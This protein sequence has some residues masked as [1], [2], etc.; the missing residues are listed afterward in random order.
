MTI[1][2]TDEEHGPARLITDNELIG[3]FAMWAIR[4]HPY[5]RPEGLFDVCDRLR[6][7]AKDWPDGVPTLRMWRISGWLELERWMRAALKDHPVLVAWNT[8]RSRHTQAIVA[9]SRYWGPKPEDDFIDIDALLRN[10]AFGMWR[11]GDK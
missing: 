3:Y 9:S 7:V 4:Q 10:V 8:P 11:E 5:H 6:E 1:T 2:L